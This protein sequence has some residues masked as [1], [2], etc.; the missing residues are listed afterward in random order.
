MKVTRIGKILCFTILR[1]ELLILLENS[2]PNLEFMTL[3][4]KTMLIWHTKEEFTIKNISNKLDS[5]SHY[6]VQ[7]QS[8][9]DF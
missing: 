9:G 7:K 1:G 2:L 6:L 3:Y 4:I 5:N 8:S